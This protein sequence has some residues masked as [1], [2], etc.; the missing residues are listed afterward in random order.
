[1]RTLLLAAI[2]A[3]L[4]TAC[5]PRVRVKGNG[6]IT[7]ETRKVTNASKIRLSGSYTV[8][9]SKGDIPSLRIETDENVLAYIETFNE[10]DWLIIRQKDRTNISTARPIKVYITTNELDAIKL[11]GSGDLV[12]KDKFT[13]TQDVEISISGVGNADLQLNAPSI[14]ANISGSGNVL[15]EGE[16]RKASVH[17]SG[18]GDYKGENLMAEDVD[19]HVSGSGNATV[20]AEERLEVHVSGSGD[21]RYKGKAA[22]IEKHI[23]GSGSVRKIG[24]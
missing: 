12:G 11:S 16:T 14:N 22:N 21:V 19:V 15:L 3:L 20:Y 5:E 7:T 24:E 9:L 18:H 10:N 17:I 8:E 2:A 6:N 4:F 13:S 1:M 23:S